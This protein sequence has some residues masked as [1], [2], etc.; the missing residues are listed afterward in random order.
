MLCHLRI[1]NTLNVLWT[2][3]ELNKT[4]HNVDVG[5]GDSTCAFSLNWF[6]NTSLSLFSALD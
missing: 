4:K 5:Y 1:P 6:G 2:F 3:G